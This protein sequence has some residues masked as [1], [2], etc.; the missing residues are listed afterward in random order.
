MNELW[1]SGK[2]NANED[3]GV[4]EGT[5][6]MKVSAYDDDF[7]SFPITFAKEPWIRDLEE[8]SKQAEALLEATKSRQ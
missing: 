8:L 6:R 5:L 1:I 2:G 4:F 3:R 7:T